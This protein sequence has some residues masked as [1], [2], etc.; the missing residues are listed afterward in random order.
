MLE[1]RSLMFAAR[2]LLFQV[3]V[4]KFEFE[5]SLFEARSL[6]FEVTLFPAHLVYPLDGAPFDIPPAAEKLDFPH[7]VFTYIHTYMHT[8]AYT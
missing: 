2:S 8:Y 4:G 3:F 7:G 6:M 5:V 1:E